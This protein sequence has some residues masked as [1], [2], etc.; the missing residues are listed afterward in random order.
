[1]LFSWEIKVVIGWLATRYICLHKWAA[2]KKT[3]YFTLVLERYH[4]NLSL[5]YILLPT[6]LRLKAHHDAWNRNL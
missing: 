2:N 4:T 6:L 1:M 5:I 3:T